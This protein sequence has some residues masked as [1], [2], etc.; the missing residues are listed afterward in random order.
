MSAFQEVPKLAI[1]LVTAYHTVT[2]D[3]CCGIVGNHA[4]HV[5]FTEL[6]TNC[7]TYHMHMPDWNNT[8]SKQWSKGMSHHPLGWRLPKSS[9]QPTSCMHLK[10]CH[11]T[12]SHPN[13]ESL[14]FSQD[15]C[16]HECTQNLSNRNVSFTLGG[17][18]PLVLLSQ[19]IVVYLSY[20]VG[21]SKMLLP[22]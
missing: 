9:C 13:T 20:D 22:S 3:S 2:C 8:H 18:T 17:T 1:S 16:T 6:I 12:N 15:T 14:H 11:C 19:L 4:K 5:I 7:L 21:S 10:Y